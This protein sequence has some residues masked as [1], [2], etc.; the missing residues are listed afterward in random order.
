LSITL[1]KYFTLCCFLLQA[2]SILHRPNR[3]HSVALL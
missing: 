1:I 2:V 3:Y